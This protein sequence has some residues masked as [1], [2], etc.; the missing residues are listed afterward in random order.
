MYILVANIWKLNGLID[1]CM[2]VDTVLSTVLIYLTKYSTA[3][4][5]ISC[6]SQVYIIFIPSLYSELN[7]G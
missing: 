4:Y 6:L 1:E 7:E 5:I 2:H 3:G